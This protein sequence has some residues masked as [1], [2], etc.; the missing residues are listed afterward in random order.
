MSNFILFILIACF[1]GGSFL[2]IHPLVSQMPPLL[3]GS[4]R[5]LVAILFLAVL[6]PIQKV[7]F[8][9]PKEARVDV[10]WTGFVAFSLPFALLF[11]GEK[12]ISAGLA[13]VLNGTVPIWVFI[14]GS[15]F[16]PGQE[17]ITL[18]KVAGLLLGLGGVVSIFYPKIVS[19]QA[20][21]SIWGTLAVLG[22][23]ISYGTS[24]LLNRR[25]FS[26]FKTLHPLT[27]LFHQLVSGLIASL[28]ISFIF[29]GF[30]NPQEWG[31]FKTILIAELYLGCISTGVAF[32]LF[33]KLI[34]VWGSVRAAT[35]TYVVPAV[36]LGF[37]LLINSNVPGVHELVGVLGITL[38]VVILNFPVLEKKAR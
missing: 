7:K 25:V 34:K 23:A 6:M 10:W 38:G 29:E 9:L 36:A 14:L 31:S 26:E 11:W 8:K 27:N 33:Y 32:L 20:D 35:V 30:P 24:V 4:L 37:D 17:S 15:I 28:L 16:T 3:A 19:S 13:G 18:R 5:I 1:W 2:A 22:M 21:P 12:S